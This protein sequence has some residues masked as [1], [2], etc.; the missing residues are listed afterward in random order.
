MPRAQLAHSAESAAISRTHGRRF[1]GDGAGPHEAG[2]GK[3]NPPCVGVGGTGVGG[4]GGGGGGGGSC[5]RICAKPDH[6]A[7]CVP[8]RARTRHQRVVEY[9][10][11]V[12]TVCELVPAVSP[13]WRVYTTAPA[14]S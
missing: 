11:S 9:A 14:A 1:A 13:I 3:G 4:A 8:S 6:G 12:S 10:T 7:A 2:I 5:V